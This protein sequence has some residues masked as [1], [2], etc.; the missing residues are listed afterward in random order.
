VLYTG[1]IE[2]ILGGDMGTTPN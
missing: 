1:P 2:F